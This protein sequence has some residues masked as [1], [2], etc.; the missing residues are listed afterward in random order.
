VPADPSTVLCFP[1]RLV[2]LL[3]EDPSGY[4]NRGY[5]WRKLGEYEAAVEDYTEAI[6]L[7]G[8]GSVRLHNNRAYCLAKLGRYSEAVQDY[9]AVLAADPANVHA[10]HNRWGWGRACSWGR[11]WGRGFVQLWVVFSVHLSM[12]SGA[13]AGRNSALAGCSPRHGR[14]DSTKPVAAWLTEGLCVFLSC[15]LQ[16]HLL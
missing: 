11:S 1:C 3:P 7:A 9:E 16:G 10:Y 4:S 12:A 14:V 2:Q 6:R 15:V 5:A 8:S 13:A